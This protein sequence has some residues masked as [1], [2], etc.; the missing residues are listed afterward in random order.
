MTVLLLVA[1][2]TSDAEGVASLQSLTSRVRARFADEVELAFIDHAAPSVSS[3]L[4]RLAG[5]GEPVLVVPLLLSA[6]SHSKGDVPAAIQ[7]AS[8][9]HPA[10]SLSYAR[11][12]GPHRLLISL[13]DRRL[14]EAGVP[15]SAAVVLVSAG[16]ADPAANADVSAV[17]RLLFEWRGGGPVEAAYA[18]AT[19]PTVV[20]ALDRLA[21]LGFADRA[22]APYFLAPGRFPMAVRAAAGPGVRVAEVLGDAEE[23]VELVLERA[24]EAARGDVRMSCEICIY[25]APWPGRE[26]RAGAPQTVHPHPAD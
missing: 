8:A 10:A 3:A 23:L 4:L 25:R 6:A 13:L 18:S 5:A 21:R 15:A 22:V 7:A 14:Q 12:L 20:E 2:G 9:A 17:A 11:P 19:S 26:D 1:H 16:A 24:A